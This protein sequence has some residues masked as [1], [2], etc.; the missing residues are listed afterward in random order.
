MVPRSSADSLLKM[1]EAA[2]GMKAGR[3]A[4]VLVPQGR[5][6]GMHCSQAASRLIF[7]FKLSTCFVS[8]C[9]DDRVQRYSDVSLGLYLFGLEAGS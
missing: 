8:P 6:G 1:L 2:R 9:R 7:V 5:S 3:V 4:A